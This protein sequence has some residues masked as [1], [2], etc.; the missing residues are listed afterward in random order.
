[1]QQPRIHVSKQKP[2]RRIE[3]FSKHIQ[4]VYSY[5]TQSYGN[6]LEEEIDRFHRKQLRKVLGFFWPQ[7]ISNKQLYKRTKQLPWS[8][9]ILRRC[10]NWFG[11]L[12]RRSKTSP[13]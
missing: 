8:A 2:R 4:K 12:L 13:T 5:T 10:S 11:H 3:V 6:S 7:I 9:A 1:M